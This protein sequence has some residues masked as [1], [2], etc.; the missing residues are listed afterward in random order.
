MLVGDAIER[1]MQSA[2]N[3]NLGASMSFVLMLLIII[4]MTVLNKYAD[5][6]GGVII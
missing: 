4:S 1:Q 6:D 2:Y 5:E 3:Y